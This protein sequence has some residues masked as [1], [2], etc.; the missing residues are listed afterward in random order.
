MPVTSNNPDAMTT[1]SLV[2]EQASVAKREVV[3]GRVR[4]RTV[5]D[6]KQEVVQEELHGEDIE[7]RRVPIDCYVEDGAPQIR[8]EGAVTIVPIVEEVLVVEKRL[9]IKEE[10][11]IHR[12]ATTET[13]EVPVM[14]R[15]QRAV[16]ERLNSEGDNITGPMEK[17]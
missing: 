4:V 17:E 11:H 12:R 9:L 7:V 2:E 3:T 10:V 1:L 14:V 13:A 15:K 8:T 16:I 5:T 6:T